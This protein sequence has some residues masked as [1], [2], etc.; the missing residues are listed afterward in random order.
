MGVK[1]GGKMLHKVRVKAI[2]NLITV[3]RHRANKRGAERPCIDVD[4]NWLIRRYPLHLVL[5]FAKQFLARGVDVWMIT[6]NPT[7]Y[8]H[9][10]KK[11]TI[12]RDAT[13]EQARLD[14]I[15]LRQHMLALV[16]QSRSPESSKSRGS[17]VS[18]VILRI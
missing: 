7:G 17:Q 4:V 15:G 5:A 1:S 13:C 18:T 3:L 9:H 16:N 12:D 11:A 14:S 6:D 10:S 2:D 8:R